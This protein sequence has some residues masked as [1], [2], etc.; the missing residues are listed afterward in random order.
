MTLA[1]VFKIKLEIAKIMKFHACRLSAWTENH[2]NSCFQIWVETSIFKVF[3]RRRKNRL[4]G[5]FRIAGNGPSL[6]KTW[7]SK[8][9]IKP[10]RVWWFWCYWGAKNV[11]VVDFSLVF[12]M[13]E[14]SWFLACWVTF[15]LVILVDLWV[16]KN[17]VFYCRFFY[18]V[19]GFGCLRC[20][21]CDSR[22]GC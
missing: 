21:F 20:H 6:A 13:F 8:N 2:N 11:A 22:V 16:F 12:N 9:V 4:R 14:R 10:K 18:I 17:V 1:L 7:F 15:F 19:D 3:E 5:G